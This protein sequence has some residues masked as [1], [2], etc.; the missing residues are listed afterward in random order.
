MTAHVAEHMVA[1]GVLRVPLGVD[2]NS[3]FGEW[4]TTDEA[5]VRKQLLFL[6]GIVLVIVAVVTL[7]P[8]L[9]GLRTRLS[10]ANPAWLALGAV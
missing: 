6:T 2:F 5:K 4:A 1:G 9:N 7:L 10:H 8:G 3:V